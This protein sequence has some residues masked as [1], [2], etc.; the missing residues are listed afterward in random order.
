[1][2][3]KDDPDFIKLIEEHVKLNEETGGLEF[4]ELYAQQ[5]FNIGFKGKMIVVPYSHIVWLK[6]H[7]RWPIKGMH[8][9]HVNDNPQDNR[10]TNL[11]ELTEEE[12]KKKRRGRM[13][14]RSY[15]T[16]K[17][18]YGMGI[19]NDK[20]DNRFY[21]SRSMSRGHGNGDLKTHSISLGGFDTREEAEAKIA[22][23]IKEI[24][25]NG[26]DHIPEAMP[27]KGKKRTTVW[28]N[29]AADKMK[30]LRLQGHTIAQIAEITGFKEGVVYKRVRSL[31]VDMRSGDRGKLRRRI[32]LKE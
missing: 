23:Y 28:Y 21:V 12:S 20:R 1:M 25:E 7:K 10:P 26:L 29:T 30:E 32:R 3:R 27:N 24:Q 22:S 4:T 31:G 16:G 13:V 6:K 17:Y 15:G 9:D 11:Q 5:C 2:S 14:Y 18:G 19:Y 8:V